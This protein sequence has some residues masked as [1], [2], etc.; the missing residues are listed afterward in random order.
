MSSSLDAM[1]TEYAA[2]LRD[3]LAGSGE[4]ATLRAYELGRKAIT[5]GVGLIELA[6]VHGKAVAAALRAAGT[7]EEK[8]RLA[9]VAADFMAEALS[10]FEMAQRGF[11]EVNRTLADLNQT[12]THKNAD[13][14]SANKELAAL[15]RIKSQFLANMSHELRTPLNAI[16]GFSEML[17]REAFG[18]LQPKQHRYVDNILSSG[19]HLLTLINDVLDLSKV[20]AGKMEL[21]L[22]RVAVRDLLRET[23]TVM[24]GMA[25]RKEI[26]LDAEE[27]SESLCVTGDVIRL[28]QVIFNLLSNAIKFTP[29]GGS[30]RLRAAAGQGFAVISVEDTG[31]G[32]A[33]EDQQRIF[34]EFQ[35][36]ASGDSRE[37]QGT[38]LGLALTQRLVDLHGGQITVASEVGKGSTFTFTV[39]LAAEQS[40]AA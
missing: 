35:Q 5:D 24:K 23:A 30:V 18:P 17:Q 1:E 10:P 9:A 26:S 22:G 33:S 11:I 34:D 31:V 8:A 32:I 2:A 40:L 20:E 16:I 14:D 39:P 37:F 21:R 28:K 27:T 15:S 4:E 38:G 6:A 36:L 29:A 7:A 25:D 13:L 19:R 12:L 3:Y